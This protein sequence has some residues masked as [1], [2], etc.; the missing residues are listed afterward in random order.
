MSL[1]R[2]VWR[3][4]ARTVRVGFLDARALSGLCVWMAHMCTFTF[5]LSAVVMLFFL[6]LE[7]YGISVPAA[8]RYC[9]TLLFP[10]VRP[11]NSVYMENKRLS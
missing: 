9:R 3:D 11:V 4:S 10:G 7:R 2:N 8:W 5:V 6:I 1:E